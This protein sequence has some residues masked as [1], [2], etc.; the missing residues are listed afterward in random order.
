MGLFSRPLV[1]L[2]LSE[3]DG[4]HDGELLRYAS[5]ALLPG[6]EEV[7]FAHVV[8]DAAGIGLDRDGEK[9]LRDR[10]HARVAADFQ[11]GASRCAYDVVPGARL[12][13]LLSLAV[14]HRND[15]ILLGHRRDRK[16]QRSL[17]RRLAMVAP[18][19]VWLVPEG[20]RCALEQ[21]LVPVDFS[22]ASAQA[23]SLATEL[24]SR[25]G[26]S[27]CRALHVVFDPSTVRYDEHVAEILG[28]EEA[29]FARLLA[30]VDRHG[31]RV[32]TVVEESARPAGT[33]LRVA[34]ATGTD[35]I[36]MSTR[37]RSA[38][39]AVLLGSVTSE[40]MAR[41]TT[42]LLAIKQF[43]ARL[44]LLDTLLDPGT[45]QRPVPKTN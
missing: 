33:I 18:C 9:S 8:G 15:L 40:V 35:L 25:I 4:E 37:G 31:V 44:G 2:S 11:A 14:A 38:A 30:A 43:G 21:I 27:S 10:M 36:A 6:C 1:A 19:S 29:A 45:W 24:A 16:G 28:R 42:P 39:A 32:E 3:H 22:D 5:Q 17:A 23:L 41:T 26:L 20:A 34:E 7:R 12:D 13:G